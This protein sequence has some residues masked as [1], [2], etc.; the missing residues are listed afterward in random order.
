MGAQ[1]DVI[2]R[3][4]HAR[5]AN[6]LVNLMHLNTA[7]ELWNHLDEALAEAQHVWSNMC[8]GKELPAPHADASLPLR[9]GRGL[10]TVDGEGGDEHQHAPQRM[11]LQ[12]IITSPR[13]FGLIENR[14][15]N[16]RVF[17]RLGS[18]GPTFS[19]SEVIN[20]CQEGLQ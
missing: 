19:S 10:T 8:D 7:S 16:A 17:P 6:A 15:A 2:M 9:P 20:D 1:H 11:H 4:Y 3:A 14:H 18:D 13:V 12:T 5:T